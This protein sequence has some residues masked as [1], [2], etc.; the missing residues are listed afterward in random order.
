[1]SKRG[2]KFYCIVCNYVA[3]SS[4]SL[5]SHYKTKKH[6]DNVTNKVDDYNLLAS[7]LTS[8]NDE[9]IEFMNQSNMGC[10]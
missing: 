4:S 1:M 7:N 5:N 9:V 6:L 8:I 10:Y 2:D 3:T